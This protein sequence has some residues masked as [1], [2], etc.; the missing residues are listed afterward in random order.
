MRVCIV[1][2][3]AAQ[4]FLGRSIA[5]S[6]ETS[7]WRSLLDE[8]R[9]H[10]ERD[11]NVEALSILQKVQ[12]EAAR[13]NVSE[14]DSAEI[15]D[16]LGA[17]YEASNKLTDAQAMFNRAL[18]VRRRLLSG[19][20]SR[21][22]VSLTNESSLFWAMNQPQKAEEFAAASK[23]MWEELNDT[24]RIEYAATLN[25]LSA[26]YRLQAKL[27]EALPLMDLACKVYRRA[28]PPSSPRL[29]RALEN[30]AQ[31][32]KDSGEYNKAAELH[33]EA[34]AIARSAP[35]TPASL[36]SIILSGL[37]D[38]RIAQGRLTEAE[39]LLTQAIAVERSV[40]S[41]GIQLAV[42]YNNLAAAYR[43]LGRTAEAKEQAEAALA[44]LGNLHGQADIQRGAILNNL[45]LTAEANR[46]YRRAERLFREAA[47][48]WKSSLGNKHPNLTATYSNL[49]T[50][51]ERKG[52]F[53]KAEKMLQDV[54]ARD[55]SVLRREHPAVARDLNNLGWLEYRRRRYAQSEAYLREAVEIF[56]STLGAS[57]PDVGLSEGN[58]ASTVAA[59]K[60]ADE[61]QSLFADSLKVLEKSW[62]PENPKMIGALE[63]YAR[64]L[65]ANSQNALAE[66]TETRAM[67]IRV[68]NAIAA[69]QTGKAQS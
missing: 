48:T 28:L 34:L 22:A 44:A 57:H 56:R 11:E 62:G 55:T 41:A 5:G 40:S 51:Y 3:I 46:D 45:G 13:Q 36:L 20:D 16:S 69:E 25:N 6:G 33:E 31:G 67:H 29:L 37:G 38:L 32:L 4:I 17:A 10:Y 61:A 58:L 64:F 21:I 43:L 66:E 30:M 39:T 68:V 15:W 35:D 26:A 65:R 24:G 14:L 9:A 59:L 1:G 60:R 23:K 53:D 50:L 49:A 42:E 63:V 27:R 18:E 19:A 7:S 52:Q 2:L 8:A 54:L 12:A 47:E